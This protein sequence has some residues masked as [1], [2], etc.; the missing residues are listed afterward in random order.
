VG[1]FEFITKH[2]SHEEVVFCHDP[3]VGLK[4]IIAIHNTNLGPALGGTRMWNYKTEEEALTD[5]LR[6]SKGMTYKAAAAGLNLGGGKA[7]IMGDSKTQKTEGL[8]RAFGQF[9]NSLNGKYITAEDV[10][11]TVKD[12]EYVFMETPFVTGIPKEI[13]GSG[14]PSPY[15]AHGVLMGIKASAKW[16][17]GTD[18]LK[19][20]RVAVQGLGNVGTHL[21]K[22]LVDEGAKVIVADIDQ[23]KVK[24]HVDQ[25]KA[26]ALSVDQILFA[27][28]D[29]LAPCA[30]GA[31]VNDQSISKFKCKVI[32][33]GANNQL[34]EPRHGDQ[35]RE[36]GILYAP[37]FVV[38]AG[39]LMNVF[40][41]LEG[42]SHDR[43]FDKTRK[44]YD[45]CL[46]V[47]EIAKRDNIG[48]HT[49]ADRMAEERIKSI[50]KLKQ[51]HQGKSS[52]NFTTLKE[53]TT[54]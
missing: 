24:K 14:D 6:L 20:M 10:G 2:G 44:V 43:A 47:F 50:G 53:I 27:D 29:I 48:N 38:N 42:Y 8:F 34:A 15:T 4:A 16:K 25:Y 23:D 54:R 22:Y 9:V 41:E 45:N 21:V 3:D 7:V 31:I 52:R 39:G 11:T 17:L 5:V 18:S 51:R 19:G 49:A 33:G 40:V 1:T 35:L 12:M 26:E 32:S 37:D 46:K 13:G 28:C 36:L 30:L